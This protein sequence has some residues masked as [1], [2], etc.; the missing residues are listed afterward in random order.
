[1]YHLLLGSSVFRLFLIAGWIGFLVIP[2]ISKAQ[3]NTSYTY[4]GQVL[5]AKT[6]EPIA[7]ANVYPK[8]DP[9]G[10]ASTNFDGYYILKSKTPFD[11][12]IA[13]FIGYKTAAIALNP[14]AFKQEIDFKL[15]TNTQELEELVF[16]AGEDPAYPIMRQVIKNKKINSPA[17]SNFYEHDSY[18]K[19]EIY[20]DNIPQQLDNRR[21][22]RQVVATLDSIGR[23]EDQNG[24]RLI[25]IMISEAATRHYQQNKP[26]RSK[27]DVLKHKVTGLGIGRGRYTAQLSNSNF[28][29]HSFYE[30]WMPILGK[31]FI[32]PISDNWWIYYDYYLVDSLDIDGYWCYKIDMEPKREQDL[33]F[34]G[35]IWID[36]ESYAL[37]QVDARVNRGANINFIEGIDIYQELLPQENGAWFPKKVHTTVDVT[38]ITKSSV[39][40]IAK[41]YVQNQNYDL[42]H[43]REPSFYEETFSLH[44]DAYVY[45]KGY[46][47]TVRPDSL[48]QDE[49]QTYAMIDSLKE[50]KGVK[51]WSQVFGTIISGYKTLGPVDLGNVLKAYAYNNVEGHR[52]ELGFRTNTSF[53]HRF[54]FSGFTAYGTRDTEFKYGIGLDYFISRKHWSILGIKRTKRLDRIGVSSDDYRINPLISAILRWGNLRAQG[55]YMRRETSIYAQT[56]IIKGITGKIQVRNFSIDPVLDNYGYFLNP[57]QENSPLITRFGSSELMLEARFARQEEFLYPGNNR[58]SLGTRLLPVLTLRYTKGLQGFLEGDLD[59]HKFEANIA[60]NTRLG[61]LGRLRYQ[62]SGGFIPSQVPLPLLFVPVGN[63]SFVYNFNGF[64]TLE[65][66]EFASDRFLM[67]NLQHNFEGLL[68]NR[69]PLLKK[70]KLRTLFLSNIFWGDIRNDNLSLSPEEGPDGTAFLRPQPLDNKPFVEVGY[71]LSNIFKFL[72]ITSIHRVTYRNKPGTRNWGIFITGRLSL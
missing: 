40:L 51:T 26:Y 28:Y 55:P 46:W 69:I 41:F 71:G 5:D 50:I 45:T 4:T 68:A 47:D 12:L 23:I 14:Q 66:L 32:S 62:V 3:V 33:A 56:D 72:Q 29:N 36:S 13:S 63:E 52:F 17:S 38:Q 37:K 15:T 57:G 10:G 34:Y 60:H 61:I 35:S 39:G 19:I 11:T 31:D 44:Q 16:K 58:V 43:S 1:M 53:S 65:F 18:V 59:Y 6:G 42:N 20:L 24:D 54:V 67:L 48:S 30:N 2:A 7:F 8:K 9:Q 49:E 25:P 27:D 22:Y 64:N 21:L 70:L